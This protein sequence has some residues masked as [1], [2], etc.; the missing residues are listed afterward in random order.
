MADNEFSTRYGPW[1]VVAGGSEGIGAAFADR[2]AAQGINLVLLARRPGPLDQIA[3]R[4]RSDHGVEV[5]TAAVDLTGGDVVAETMAVVDGVDV[6]L[7]V[8]NAGAVHGAELFVQR[9]I[10]DALHL[11]DMNCR[12]VALLTH[13]F[14]GTMAERGRGGIVLMTS[15]SSGAGAALGCPQRRGWS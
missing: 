1:A 5:R 11:I 13:H 12:T 14:G 7:L 3:A 2:I 4:L 8:Y 9:P 6:G 15:I 10:E